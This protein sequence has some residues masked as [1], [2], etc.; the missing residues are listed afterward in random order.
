MKPAVE[1]TAREWNTVHAI[2]RDLAR[3][4]D[5]N[6]LGK[7]VA[8][9]RRTRSKEKFLKLLA[10]LPQSD[11]IRRSNQTQ[12]YFERIERTCRQHLA[13]ASDEKAL[14]IVAWAFRLLT[15]YQAEQE[16]VKF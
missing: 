14:A 6:E 10:Q 1:L 11:Y 9:L 5:R 3:D 13:G 15:F 16:K 12:K 8:Y 4:V 7:A 2:A